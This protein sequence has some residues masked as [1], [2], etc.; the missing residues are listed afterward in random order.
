MFALSLDTNARGSLVL[1]DFS[2]QFDS[3]L[4]YWSVADYRRHWR[5]ALQ[6]ALDDQISAL[7]TSVSDPT[8]AN[9][10]FWWPLYPGGDVVRVQNHVLFLSEHPD[11]ALARWYDVVPPRAEVNEDGDRV[12]EWSVS[13]ES[14]KACLEALVELDS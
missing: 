4:S 2:E 7:I 3:D 9:F 6:R 13:K 1:G 12:S 5:E 14:V 8:S 11:F 10:I